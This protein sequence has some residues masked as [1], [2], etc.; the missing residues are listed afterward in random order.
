MTVE[1][2][3]V[4]K[5]ECGVQCSL[6]APDAVAARKNHRPSLTGETERRLSFNSSLPMIAD[7]L[8]SPAVTEVDGREMDELEKV[9]NWISQLEHWLP[10]IRRRVV[11]IHAQKENPE[12][13]K[14]VLDRIVKLMR[15]LAPVDAERFSSSPPQLD[16]HATE[17]WSSTKTEPRPGKY[18]SLS[19]ALKE[20]QRRRPQALSDA[21]KFQSGDAAVRRRL[22]NSESN[23]SLLGD[24]SDD[25]KQSPHRSAGHD[26]A[27]EDSTKPLALQPYRPGSS[28]ARSFRKSIGF[29]G[30]PEAPSPGD[31]APSSPQSMMPITPQASPKPPQGGSTDLSSSKSKNSSGAKLAT[32]VGADIEDFFG[33]AEEPS[34]RAAS[35]PSTALEQRQSPVARP[36]SGGSTTVQALLPALVQEEV[37]GQAEFTASLSLRSSSFHGSPQNQKESKALMAPPKPQA[38]PRRPSSFLSR[39]LPS[40]NSN[41][42]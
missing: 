24:E 31:S 34:E 27:G 11:A 9:I 12:R 41:D 1:A 28:L 30:G 19:E 6:P 5:A 32:A 14:P 17:N 10:H 37:E 13:T 15:A 29:K 22:M 40:W 26:G 21:S 20:S 16:S 8:V 7:C 25:G 3:L 23:E 35:A 33:K 2:M 18:A 4:S 36:S 39:V 38:S 42:H